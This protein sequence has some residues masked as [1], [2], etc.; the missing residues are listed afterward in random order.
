MGCDLRQRSF[1]LFLVCSAD[2]DLCFFIAGFSPTPSNF[3]VICLRK[4]F[5]FYPGGL[6]APLVLVPF[7]VQSVTYKTDTSLTLF[8]LSE[9]T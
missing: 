2:L 3:I 6:S 9:E 7:F 4:S 8:K 1:L 5:Q